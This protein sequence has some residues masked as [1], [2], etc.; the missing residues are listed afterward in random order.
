MGADTYTSLATAFDSFA[1]PYQMQWKQPDLFLGVEGVRLPTIVFEVGWSQSHPQLIAAK[2][3][4]LQGGG[5]EVNAVFLIKWTK[6]NERDV[7]GVL[8]VFRGGGTSE[9]HVSIGDTK[10][11]FGC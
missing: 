1:E 11:G 9:G 6:V 3:L 4:W 8:E 7:K 5:N 10:F 2:N